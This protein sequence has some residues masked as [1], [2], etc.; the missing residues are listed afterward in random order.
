MGGEG[1]NLLVNNAGILIKTALLDTTCEDMQTTFNTNVLGPMNMMKVSD[2][3][4][5][6]VSMLSRLKTRELTDSP[7]DDPL[8]SG[9]PAVSPHSSKGQ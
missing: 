8:S 9:V 7:P 1:L 6:S 2:G 3:A 5:R 4:A